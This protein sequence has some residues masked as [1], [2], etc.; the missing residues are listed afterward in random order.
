MVLR[1]CLSLVAFSAVVAS[2][3]PATVPAPAP[4]SAPTP[5]PAPTLDTDIFVADLY[6]EVG[7]VAP[8]TNVTDRD[9]YDNQP[10]FTL[11]GSALLYVADGEGAQTDVWRYEF[12]GGTRVQ[13]TNTPE[14]EFSPTPLPSGGFSAVR[15]GAPSAEGEA[16]TESQQLYRYGMDGVAKSPVVIG[17][18]RVGYH[19]W[20]EPTRF[21]AFIVGGGEA[22]LP[23]RL[24]LVES[25]TGKL[26]PLA[27]DIGRSLGRAPDGR[28][29]FVDK[30]N[31]KAWTVAT[32]APGEAKPRALIATPPGPADEPERDRSEDFC[33]LPDGSLLMAKGKW[34]LRWDGKPGSGWTALGELRDLPG[35]VKRLAVSRDGR[36]LAMVVEIRDP[37]RTRGIRG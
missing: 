30:G 9:G 7:K 24:V 35:D 18:S 28:V 36:R 33:W 22:K 14:A 2:A 4:A 6:L 31:P 11:D 21:A 37:K 13:V 29:T 23:H 10:A 16:Y 5:A 12:A 20:I 8:A 32:I 3:A 17:L 27:L 25:D 19:A 1:R 15:V 26:T 34:L